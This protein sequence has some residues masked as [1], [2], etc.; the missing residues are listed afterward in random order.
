MKKKFFN[1]EPPKNN[2]DAFDKILEWLTRTGASLCI[3]GPDRG[4]KYRNTDGNN[5]C[6][7][8][9]LTPDRM[10]RI[11]DRSKNNTDIATVLDRYPSAKKW[12]EKCDVEFLMDMQAFHDDYMFHAD[13]M[14]RDSKST[15]LS[16]LESTAKT[17]K[18]EIPK[19]IVA[20]FSK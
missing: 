10:A 5:A 13:Y 19:D 9:V 17:Y 2:Q 11:I 6:A 20:F 4:C 3:G 8:G 18:L 16:I 15:R 12:F 14:F 7:I 1:S